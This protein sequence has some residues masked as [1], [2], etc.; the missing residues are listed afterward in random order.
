[1]TPRRLTLRGVKLKKMNIYEKHVDFSKFFAEIQSWLTLRGVNSGQAN[2]ARS[3]V[4]TNFFF[5]LIENFF[6]KYMRTISIWPNIFSKLFNGLACKKNSN[7]LA[8]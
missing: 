7:I 3:F 6:Y 2:T 5:A 1:M 8:K 4:G